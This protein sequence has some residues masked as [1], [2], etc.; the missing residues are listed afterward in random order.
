M[1][2]RKYNP[3]TPGTR[4][5]VLVDRS[6]LYKGKPVKALTRRLEQ[7][8]TDASLRHALSLRAR[9]SAQ[10]FDLTNTLL[11][12]ATELRRAAAVLPLSPNAVIE[13]SSN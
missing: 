4:Q 7:V 9:Q 8:L 11:Q 6:S 12:L 1:A 2:L 10:R 3:K 13:K 5:L